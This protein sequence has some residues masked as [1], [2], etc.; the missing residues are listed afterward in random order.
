MSRTILRRLG[1]RQDDKTATTGKLVKEVATD[2]Q[3]PVPTPKPKT[4]EELAQN[5][6]ALL[7]SD[8]NQETVGQMG[9]KQPES[10]EELEEEEETE[11]K[12]RTFEEISKELRNAGV[13]EI[14]LGK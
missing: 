10:E 11:G 14:H 13:R 5:P 6:K 12:A 2:E 4:P 9:A 3:S 8:I 7:D 1:V